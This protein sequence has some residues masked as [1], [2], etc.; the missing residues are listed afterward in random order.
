MGAPSPN[1]G[2]RWEMNK[3]KRIAVTLLVTLVAVGC[4]SS[5]RIEQAPQA[6]EAQRME[7][8]PG[9]TTGGL[10]F[11]AVVMPDAQVPLSFRIPGYVVS[12]LPNSAEIVSASIWISA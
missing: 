7:S 11:S 12:M 4:H 2:G 1:Y 5:T 10:R 3:V 9:L 6:V 8:Q